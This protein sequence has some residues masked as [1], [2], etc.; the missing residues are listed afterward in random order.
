MPDVIVQLQVVVDLGDGPSKTHTFNN[1]AHIVDKQS[2]WLH[3]HDQT[4][5]VASFPP[6]VS[7]IAIRD[8][9]PLVSGELK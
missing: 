2:G 7:P 9:A 5:T 4:G 3:V 8:P 6:S 1:A